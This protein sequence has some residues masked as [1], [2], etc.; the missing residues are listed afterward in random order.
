MRPN[1]AAKAL[2]PPATPLYAV[3]VR[4]RKVVACHMPPHRLRRVVHAA[5]LLRCAAM[6]LFA[7][8]GLAARP[9]HLQ[10]S[11]GRRVLQ[12][13]PTECPATC[14]TCQRDPVDF[15]LVCTA[16][17]STSS[18]CGAG[19]E[20]CNTGV[21]CAACVVPEPDGPDEPSG[22]SAGW[23]IIIGF[24]CC[25][26][27][28]TVGGTY[29]GKQADP[30]VTVSVAHPHAEAWQQLPRLVRDGVTF[31]KAMLGQG[32]DGA[33]QFETDALVPTQPCQPP[34]QGKSSKG[35][36]KKKE[37][38]KSNKRSDNNKGRKTSKPKPRIRAAIDTEPISVFRGKGTV[39]ERV[40][41]I[42]VPIAICC[43]AYI[44]PA[45]IEFL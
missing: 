8:C 39:N 3:V 44:R 4:R 38:K 15:P 19:P 22:L 24:T 45:A 26:V 40:T 16:C 27:V 10:M 2:L 23:L 13:I 36:E 12:E 6:V 33:K 25:F 17:C 37:K 29:Y 28:Y 31:T 21:D 9:P 1:C 20:W 5:F 34:A 42:E 14:R 41:D 11:V 32:G 30:S 43:F 18:W 35:K 7:Q